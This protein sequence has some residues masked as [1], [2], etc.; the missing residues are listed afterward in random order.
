MCDNKCNA[1]SDF[2]ELLNPSN[3]YTNCGCDDKKK[4]CTSCDDRIVWEPPTFSCSVPIAIR[5]K[6]C[7]EGLKALV[8]INNIDQAILLA[9]KTNDYSPLSRI[10]CTNTILKIFLSDGTLIYNSNPLDPTTP[11][12]FSSLIASVSTNNIFTLVGY[13]LSSGTIVFGTKQTTSVQTQSNPCAVP[14]EGVDT[15]YIELKVTNIL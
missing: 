9:V 7:A 8:C 10:I 12:E 15:I 4:K 3:C 13:N 5:A 1:K 2:K 6:I 11:E 14:V